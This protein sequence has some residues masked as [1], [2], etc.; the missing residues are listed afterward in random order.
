MT[1]AGKQIT[2]AITRKKLLTS[3]LTIN[4]LFVR[5]VSIDK[6]LNAIVEE[7][8]KIFDLT[9]VAIFMVNKKARLLQTEYVSPTCFTPEQM[10]GI[11]TMPLPL[12][13]H[14]C[15]GPQVMPHPRGMAPDMS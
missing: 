5:K 9:R 15:G 13:R 11:M 4:Q 14:P 3:I 12:G 1:Q 7:T 2:E 8:Q 6:V 10:E